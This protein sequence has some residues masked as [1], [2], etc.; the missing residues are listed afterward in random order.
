M[1]AA[2]RPHFTCP[3][4]TTQEN[5]RKLYTT[6]N[7]LKTVHILCLMVG[8]VF[9]FF[10]HLLLKVLHADEFSGEAT[11]AL[12][13]A[14]GL[15]GNQIFAISSIWGDIARGAATACCFSLHG[16]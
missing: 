16:L 12:Y 13:L 11:T 14:M 4:C 8:M 1:P 6:R 5:L 3:L 9:C 7:V 2:V 15:L 10:P